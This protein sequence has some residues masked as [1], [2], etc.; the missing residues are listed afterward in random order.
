MSAPAIQAGARSLQPI[1]AVLVGTRHRGTTR[2]NAASI[3]RSE[4][5]TSDWYGLNSTGFRYHVVARQRGQSGMVDVE[6]VLTL[7]L[8][9]QELAEYLTRCCLDG[10]GWCVDEMAGS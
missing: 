2:A 7:H 6:T 5:C 10:S 4:L 1:T 3:R 8:S 9:D